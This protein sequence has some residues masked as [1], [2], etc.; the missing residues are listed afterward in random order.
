MNVSLTPRK[1]SKLSQNISENETN[2]LPSPPDAPRLDIAIPTHGRD[3]MSRIVAMNLPQTEGVK[4]YISWQD[5]GDE[6]PVP[7]EIARR[8]DITVYRCH[9]KGVSANRNNALDMCTAPVV[10]MGDD[11]LTYSAWQLRNVMSIFTEHPEVDLATF[12]YSNAVKEYPPEECDLGFPLP[13]NYGV[14]TFEIAARRNVLEKIRFDEHFGPGA[15]VWHAGEDEKFL[16]DAR[17]KGFHCRFFPIDI[18]LH[19]GLTTGD[20][21]M[22]TPGVAAASGRLIRLEYP[23]SWFPRVILKSLRQRRIGGRVFFSFFHQL[24]GAFSDGTR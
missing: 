10:L 13:K 9:R 15:P 21:P 22:A 17:C 8:V 24:R 5:C 2:A 11:D 18:T 14:A 19:N 4:Y 20:K 23:R 7:Y 3:A 12:R 6:A 1:L 16:Y